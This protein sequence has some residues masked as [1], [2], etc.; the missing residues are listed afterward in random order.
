M[1]IPV[2]FS[3]VLAASL[4]GAT[5]APADSAPEQL[6][7]LIATEAI[8]GG[9]AGCPGEAI[10]DNGDLIELS[11]QGVLTLNPK[12]AVGGGVF[13]H[14]FAAGGSMTGTWTAIQLL[15]FK[16]YGPSPLLPPSFEAGD[17]LILVHLVD[18]ETGLG[19]DAILRVG[20]IL[21]QVKLPPATFEG[22]RLSVMGGVNFNKETQPRAT[23]FIRQQ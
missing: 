21:P 6:V 19:G 3:L 20:C 4:A 14:S 11:G 22:I 18:S 10:A 9:A 7:Y 12:S 1:R 2:T 5:S 17:A 15:S 23:L 8:C 13:T 16:S